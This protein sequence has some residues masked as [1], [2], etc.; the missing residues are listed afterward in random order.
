MLEINNTIQL[1]L[2]TICTEV[3]NKKKEVNKQLKRCL[4]LTLLEHITKPTTSAISLFRLYSQKIMGTKDMMP[5]HPVFP[6]SPVHFLRSILKILIKRYLKGEE[7]I[8]NKVKIAKM[9]INTHN[10][11]QYNNQ[12]KDQPQVYKVLTQKQ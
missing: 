9:Q 10:T 5:A 8:V 11:A 6:N 12:V 3:P 1:L 2:K 4:L 7:I